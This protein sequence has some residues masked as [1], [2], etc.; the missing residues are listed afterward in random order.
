MTPWSD[1]RRLAKP[2]TTASDAEPVITRVSTSDP[3]VMSSKS[4]CTA[5]L[6]DLAVVAIK[7][8]SLSSETGMSLDTAQQPKK[9]GHTTC[10]GCQ[11][12][13]FPSVNKLNITPA[14]AVPKMTCKVWRMHNTICYRVPEGL[15]ELQ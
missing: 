9:S 11:D 10:S 12:K 5:N 15:R 14:K 1:A 13:S 4:L 8:E 6:Y 2:A 7:Q 3:I